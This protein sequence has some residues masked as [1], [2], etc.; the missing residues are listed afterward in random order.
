MGVYNYI[1]VDP[2]G[3][4][5]KGVLEGDSERHI[6][7]QLRDNNLL[8]IDVISLTPPKKSEK[9]IWSYFKKSTDIK[10]EFIGMIA[11][12]GSQ[13]HINIPKGSHGDV[14]NFKEQKLDITITITKRI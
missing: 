13:L 10:L 3:N 7:Q 5:S 1:A 12:M 9:N 8:P 11:K 6:R 14:A 2:E 4:E